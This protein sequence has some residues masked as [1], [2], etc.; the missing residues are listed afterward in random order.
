MK[1]RSDEVWWE[2]DE[3]PVMDGPGRIVLVSEPRPSVYTGLLDASGHPIYR[4]PVAKP[5]MGF[6]CPD[7]LL[8]LF[9]NDTDV[10]F[11]YSTDVDVELEED[12]E[13]D[14]EEEG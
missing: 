7:D 14:Q 2:E 12:Y 8:H 10:D 6:V 11:E 13:P 5:P 1:V 3:P 9:D 4:V